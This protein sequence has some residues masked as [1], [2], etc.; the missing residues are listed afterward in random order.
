MKN[1]AFKC[2]PGVLHTGALGENGA[3]ALDC[4]LRFL[5]DKNNKPT[6]SVPAQGA[7]FFL[8]SPNLISFYS[9]ALNQKILA[10]TSKKNVKS[11]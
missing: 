10:D 9:I 2:L 1:R 5:P 3:Q 11:E 6:G 4:E 7:R 8:C